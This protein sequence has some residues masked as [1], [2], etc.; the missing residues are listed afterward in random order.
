M[1][2]IG[3]TGGEQSHAEEVRNSEEGSDDEVCEREVGNLGG[4]EE[5]GGN[6]RQEQRRRRQGEVD[7]VMIP[8]LAPVALNQSPSSRRP[9]RR[10]RYSSSW[11]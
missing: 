5:E 1:L 4:S 8:G 10:K 7:A 2:Q 11:Q 3:G 9:D 6:Q